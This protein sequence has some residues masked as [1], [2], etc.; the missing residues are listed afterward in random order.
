MKFDEVKLS[1]FALIL[2]NTFTFLLW[3][4][5]HSNYIPLYDQLYYLQLSKE[6]FE[7]IKNLDFSVLFD[8]YGEG[9]RKIINSYL[10]FV[11]ISPFYAIFGF[12]IEF[13][14]FVNW[15]ALNLSFFLIYKLTK[16]FYDPKK[17]ILASFIF[18][19][20]PA[21]YWFSKFFFLEVL[22]IPFLLL[23]FYF[24]KKTENFT[25]RS[26]SLVYGIVGII[27]ILIKN[28]CIVPILVFHFHQLL[29]SKVWQKKTKI[30]NSFLSTLIFLTPLLLYSFNLVSSLPLKLPWTINYLRPLII[31]K[32]F[33]LFPEYLLIHLGIIWLPIFTLSLFKFFKKNES[34]FPFFTLFLAYLLIF[35]LPFIC[36]PLPQPRLNIILL[37]FFAILIANFLIKYQKIWKL[38]VILALIYMFFDLNFI[39]MYRP[40]LEKEEYGLL[41][42][43][44]YEKFKISKFSPWIGF[45]GEERGLNFNISELEKILQKVSELEDP[46]C[47]VFSFALKDALEFLSIKQNFPASFTNLC[48]NPQIHEIERN[49]NCIIVSDIEMFFYKKK[50]FE[51]LQ[52]LS[53]NLEKNPN[54]EFA[55]KYFPKKSLEVKIYVKK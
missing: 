1:F 37:P 26:I 27:T 42:Y 41:K 14:L 50:H 40:S 52:N 7:R 45:T 9:L 20:F 12:S 54:F 11:L 33:L 10:P 6:T 19:T 55:G 36:L 4:Y 38:L 43:K 29:K 13:Y 48:E 22:S 3:F 30:F 5:Q 53:E 44:W 32:F 39:L 35:F 47:F 18:L 24:L 23:T 17:G 51:F 28:I 46:K 21:I 15:L 31:A 34:D 49:H 2:L 16:E 8:F 25:R